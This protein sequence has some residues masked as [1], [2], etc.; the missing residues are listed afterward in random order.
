MGHQTGCET[1]RTRT[2]VTIKGIR[3]GLVFILHDESSMEEILDDLEEKVNGTHRQLLTG[4]IVKVTVQTGARKFSVEQE[5]K[6]RK[7]L[8]SHGNLI[9]QEFQSALDAMLQVQKPSQRICYGT[10]RSGQVIDHDGDVVIIG[11]INPGGQVLATGDIFVMGTLRG[12]AHAGCKGNEDAIIAAVFF[13]PSQLRIHDVISR[14]PDSG[15]TQPLETE[16]EFAYLRERQM[17][18]DKLS[19]LYSIRARDF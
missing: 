1:L 14:A 17:A 2:P 5:E 16:M 7:K 15:E 19:H 4:P 8:S 11:D 6:I 13:Q 3:D 12:M 18:V 9:I 10:V